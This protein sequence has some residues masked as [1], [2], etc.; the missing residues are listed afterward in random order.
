MSNLAGL[1]VTMFFM[2]LGVAFIG[3]LLFILLDVVLQPADSDDSERR[4]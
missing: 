2:V 1:L 3:G 4:F